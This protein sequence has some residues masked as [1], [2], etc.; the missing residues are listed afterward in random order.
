MTTKNY[1]RNQVIRA[2]SSFFLSLLFL[3][4][5]KRQA[6]F[7]IYAFCRAIDDVVD[8]PGVDP[9]EARLKLQEWRQEVNAI[10]DG[11]PSH[12]LAMELQ[13]AVQRF[14]LAR[15]PFLELLDGMAM[16]L[17]FSRYET[18]DDLAVYCHKV[19]VT[20]GQLSVQV[21]GLAGEEAQ[22]FAHHLGMAFQL[23]NI[24]RDLAEDGRLGRVY[25]PM[26]WLRAEGC[27]AEDLLQ[28]RFSAG[29]HRVAERMATLADRHYRQAW[30]V[31][32][33]DHRQQ[34]LAAWIMAEMYHAYLEQ[35]QEVGFDVFS[36]CVRIS[37]W[38][39]LALLWQAWLR[40]RGFPPSW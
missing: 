9:A 33:A 15:E 1:C 40:H 36:H 13:Q 31:I 34:L 25:L 27:S 12:P 23:T 10:Y 18:L 11:S 20:V 22:R 32:A 24:L 30:A 26:T 14:S 19:A 37:R 6:M 28:G 16:D 4:A 2:R 3:S 35:L 29:L 21:F 38:K 17:Q 7:A 39:K 8:Q 5:P